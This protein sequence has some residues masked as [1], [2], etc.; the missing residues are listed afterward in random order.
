MTSP[1]NRST[2]R[3]TGNAA[4]KAETGDRGHVATLA[5]DI[6]GTGLKATVLDRNGSM[7][8]N[9]VR[10]DTPDPSP[11]AVIV[12]ALVALV[13]PL[14]PFDRISIGFPGVV[15]DGYVLTAPNLGTEQWR[16]FPLA[17]ALRARLGDKPARLL[18]DAEV[19]GY[20]VICGIGLELVVTVG[21]GV[22]SA[23]FLEGELMP[24]LELG[25][26]P[27]RKKKILDDYIGDAALE[28][29]GE[30]KWNARVEKLIEALR[31]LLNFDTLYI[32]GG[33]SRRLSIKLPQDVKIVSND[34]G[35]TGGIRLWND[36]RARP[37]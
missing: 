25:Q 31:T 4:L 32:G 9:H 29:A 8:A 33:N 27:F 11:P 20:G 1:R 12:D 36:E 18:N 23:L 6:G 35:L 16:R 15:R 17:D 5:I 7:L 22:G 26:Y 10:V 3:N 13:K 21:T 30:K 37:R 2:S 28:R 14:P 34:A 24:H 19:Q